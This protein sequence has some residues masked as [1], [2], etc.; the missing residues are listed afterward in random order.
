MQLVHIYG[1]DVVVSCAVRFKGYSQCVLTLSSELNYKE[2]SQVE[3]RARKIE[4]IWM[5]CINAFFVYCST[6]CP[7]YWWNA[8]KYLGSVILMQQDLC[9]SN[10]AKQSDDLDDVFKLY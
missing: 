3:F 2:P 5:A 1:E 9:N 7:S 8:D 4:Q 6:S 10:A